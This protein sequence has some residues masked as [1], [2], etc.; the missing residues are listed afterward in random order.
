VAHG[1]E[2]VAVAP[3]AIGQQRQIGRLLDHLAEDADRL[4]KQVSLA[5]AAF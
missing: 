3:L 5:L 4:F 1:K 2:Q